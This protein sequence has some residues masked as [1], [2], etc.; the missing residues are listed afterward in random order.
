MSSWSLLKINYQ[1]MNEWFLYCISGPLIAGPLANVVG[2]K[3]TLLS[4]AAFFV[5]SFILLLTTGSVLQMC[6]ARFLQGLGVGFVMCVQPM[7]IGEISTDEV[8]GALGSF[9]QLFIVSKYLKNDVIHEKLFLIQ[10]KFKLEYCTCTL[11]VHMCRTTHYNGP[12]W[13]FL[14]PLPRDFS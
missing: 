3:W 4:S 5:V 1:P 12:V 6:I 13:P 10:D 7:Y 2:R 9:M 14:L 8:R 11:S